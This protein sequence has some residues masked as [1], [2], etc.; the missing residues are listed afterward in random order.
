MNRSP[1]A[2]ATR[3]RCP[4]CDVGPLFTTLQ[5]GGKWSV[6]GLGLANSC[7]TCEL[8]Y[9]FVDSGDGPA[10]F[11]IFI[12]GF[13]VLGGALWLEFTYLPPAWVHVLVWGV[14]T[15]SL[16]FILLRILKGALIG[17]QY[18]NGAGESGRDEEL[19]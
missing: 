17:L 2:A 6:G 11:A 19:G 1:V 14:V 12:L 16:A 4:R 7:S 5:I 10:V 18:A 3:G 13:V 9:R 15:P 8:D